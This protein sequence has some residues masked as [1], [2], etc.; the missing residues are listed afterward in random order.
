MRCY[1]TVVLIFIVG[2]QQA[3]AAE[4]LQ[5]QQRVIDVFEQ[6]RSAIAR[7]KA[8]FKEDTDD[9]NHKITLRIGT[10][11]F[12][13]SDGYILTNTSTVFNASRVWI[14]WDGV[15]IATDIIGHDP[16][17]NISMLKV[18][19]LPH[20]ATYLNLDSLASEPP[21]GTMAISISCTLDFDPAPSLGLIKGYQSSFGKRIFPT[22]LLRTSIPGGPGEAGS[23]ILDLNGRLLGILVAS[24]PEIQSSCVLPVNAMLRIRDDL[25]NQGEVNYAW[26][27]INVNRKNGAQVTIENIVKDS[28]ADNGDLKIGDIIL[29][30]GDIKINKVEDV[31]VASFKSRPGQYVNLTIL[32]EDKELTVAILV[33]KMFDPEELKEEA[34]HT[35]NEPATPLTEETKTPDNNTNSLHATPPIENK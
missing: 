10:G 22:V 5:L 27:G 30:V 3:Q 21:I 20:D 6:N 29:K 12:I 23:P 16:R 18:E 2:L 28:P 8:A 4:F 35:L 15:P 13:N 26:F 31:R 25:L 1:W 32:R 34:E 19:N 14:E 17:T 33:T 9:G 11:F 7:I 24:L